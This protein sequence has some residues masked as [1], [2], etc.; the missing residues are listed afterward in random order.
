MNERADDSLWVFA[1]GSLM[2]RPGFVF[3]EAVPA[4]LIGA[5]RA[6]CV[7]SVVHRGTPRHPGLVLGLEPGGVCCG[8]ALRVPP[9]LERATIA[10]LRRREQVTRVYRE[11]T[12]PVELEGVDACRISALCYLVDRCH[13]QYAPPMPV[14]R[15][16]DII[17]RSRGRS[18]ANIDYLVNTVMHLRDAGIRDA[19]LERI[20]THLGRHR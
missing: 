2:W 16:A 6:L 13:P 7:Y 19:N 18:G 8:L 17:R 3:E 14:N 4:R 5:H 11:A 20:L 9:G 1:Y 15:Q 12:R 10:Y